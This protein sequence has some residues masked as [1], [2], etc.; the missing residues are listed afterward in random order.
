MKI[1]RICPG[2]VQG[3]LKKIWKLYNL[4]DKNFEGII[5]IYKKENIL[6]P[7]SWSVE[8]QKR[9]FDTFEILYP[10][11]QS[12]IK[13]VYENGF[14]SSYIN[15]VKDDKFF[16]ILKYQIINYSPDIIFVYAG[17]CLYFPPSKIKILKELVPNAKFICFW[18]DEFKIVNE[19]YSSFFKFYDLVFTSNS[20]YT[21][22]FQNS[23]F[24]NAYT[25]GNCFEPNIEIKDT[26]K[27]KYNF[28]F[29]GVSGYGYPDH[30]K[31][32]ENLI[33]ILKKSDLKV[34]A[35]EPRNNYQT[36]KLIIQILENF[37]VRMTNILF[38]LIKKLFL[39]EG[40][41]KKKLQVAENI[42][43]SNKL[44]GLNFYTPSYFEKNK[45]LKSIFPNKVKKSF[46]RD[47]KS[48][49]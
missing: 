14:K 37:P 3:R 45:S 10:D 29:S 46:T 35:H 34:W 6:L 43:V 13:W 48:V 39:I 12:Q 24:T 40:Y 41:Y 4:K 33:Q 16:E 32:Y 8:M 1:L 27:K 5:D 30:I 49:V 9:G 31:R 23:G 11:I 38:K 19:T 26:D 15:S 17:A 20:A 21:Q 2:L 25:L 18:G 36:K 42:I 28:S 22:N 44:S 7:G 47:R